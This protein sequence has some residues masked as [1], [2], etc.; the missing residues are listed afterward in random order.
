MPLLLLNNIS[1]AAQALKAA[2]KEMKTAF[3]QNKE[4][5][6]S[7]IDKMQDEMFDMMVSNSVI[8]EIL[9]FWGFL[10]VLSRSRRGF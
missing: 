3:K 7:Y 2:S 5:D 4:L 6:I 1:C 8:L 10:V 9:G